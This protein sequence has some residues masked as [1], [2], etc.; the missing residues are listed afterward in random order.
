MKMWNK[1]PI[2]VQQ[3]IATKVNHYGYRRNNEK[4]VI[5]GLTHFPMVVEE[6]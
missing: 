2:R 1:L 4:L 5:W 3:Y 6:E